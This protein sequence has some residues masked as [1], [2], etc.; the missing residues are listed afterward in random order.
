M[1]FWCS[2]CLELFPWD[3]TW[4]LLIIFKYFLLQEMTS[5]HSK[6]LLSSGS[7]NP[8]H[9]ASHPLAYVAVQPRLQRTCLWA[10]IYLLLA[11]SGPELQSLLPPSASGPPLSVWAAPQPVSKH[12]PKVW[13]VNTPGVW[14]QLIHIPQPSG[15]HLA[16]I[17][18]TCVSSHR[19]VHAEKAGTFSDFTYPVILHWMTLVYV[20]CFHDSS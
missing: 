19:N 20:G 9:S 18:Y 3:F 15:G 12:R 17:L 10:R 1:P 11:A 16:G 13:G 7:R 5:G 4:S 8:P 6:I 2:L 14:S